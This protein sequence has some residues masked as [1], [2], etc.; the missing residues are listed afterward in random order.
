VRET[1]ETPTIAMIAAM[2]NATKAKS[3]NMISSFP[4]CRGE[5]T[6]TDSFPGIP[7]TNEGV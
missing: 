2:T 3:E 4:W 6:V 5:T 7:G 1:P